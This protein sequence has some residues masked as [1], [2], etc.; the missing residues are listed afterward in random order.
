[1]CCV[2]I[3]SSHNRQLFGSKEVEKNQ[4][5]HW[6]RTV[7]H[8]LGCP[9]VVPPSQ[10]SSHHQGYYTCLMGY[11]PS[12]AST[13]TFIRM[14]NKSWVQLSV[15]TRQV[16]DRD[17]SIWKVQLWESYYA[18]TWFGICI[19]S[20]KQVLESNKTE[21]LEQKIPFDKSGSKFH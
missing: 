12:Y 11:T 10:D 13:M 14:S 17:A 15:N 3:T 18:S 16:V 5:V 19:H 8:I 1:M 21:A 7:V 9:R 20:P 4:R 6:V 2:I